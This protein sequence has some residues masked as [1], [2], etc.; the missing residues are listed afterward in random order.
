MN[1]V[2]GSASDMGIP[3]EWVPPTWAIPFIAIG[4][5]TLVILV[6]RKARSDF[7]ADRRLTKKFE[8]AFP[9]RCHICAYHAYGIR[10]GHLKPGT[11]PEDHRCVEKWDRWKGCLHERKP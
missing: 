4:F 6:I 1:V 8:E 9:D 10:E 5:A 3:P 2:E 7:E 11:L